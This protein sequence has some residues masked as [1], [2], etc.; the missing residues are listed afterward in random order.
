MN[1]QKEYDDF[2]TKVLKAGRDI[3]NDFDNLSE[4]NKLRFRQQANTM[5]KEFGSA[6]AF[7]N[8]LQK[9]IK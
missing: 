6:I 9:W 2:I 4:G 1:S 8:L 3:G 7:D 5:L